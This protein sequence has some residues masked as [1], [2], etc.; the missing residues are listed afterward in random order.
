[1]ITPDSILAFNEYLKFKNFQWIELN[2]LNLLRRLIEDLV[3]VFNRNK[4]LKI[5]S[6]SWICACIIIWSI[7]IISETIFGV[8][9]STF[10]IKELLFFFISFVSSMCISSLNTLPNYH[11]NDNDKENST[12]T[13]YHNSPP[14]EICM[15]TNCWS[16]RVDRFNRIGRRI[17]RLIRI[18]FLTSTSFFIT[19]VPVLGQTNSISLFFSRNTAISN[20]SYNSF[21]Y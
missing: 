16:V 5:I 13:N 20:A 11:D 9:C 17:Y 7:H 1:M 21:F 8:N 12:Y 10:T 19:V 2:L 6:M 4:S 14:R 18:L 15:A 3:F